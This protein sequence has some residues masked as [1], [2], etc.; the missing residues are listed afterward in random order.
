MN[1]QHAQPLSTEERIRIDTQFIA[2]FRAGRF[3]ELN[4]E[5]FAVEHEWMKAP[6]R[7]FEAAVEY[8]APKPRDEW[9][10]IGGSELRVAILDGAM[11]AGSDEDVFRSWAANQFVALCISQGEDGLELLESIR[12]SSEIDSDIILRVATALESVPRF[13]ALSL[14]QRVSAALL[15]IDALRTNTP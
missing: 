4:P 15:A 13:A 8:L 14:D 11:A 5:P 9:K 12:T 2:D 10:R 7:P 1:T 6:A 3:P